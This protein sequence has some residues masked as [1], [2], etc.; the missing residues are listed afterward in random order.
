MGMKLGQ[1]KRV[2]RVLDKARTQ[3]MDFVED[4]EDTFDAPGHGDDALAVT[5]SI[6]AAPPAA[7][8][9]IAVE[10]QLESDSIG[11]I[12]ERTAAMGFNTAS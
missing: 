8:D 5:T 9:D 1:R 12:R 3:S 7:R 4:D 11:F 2:L 6:A 10:T